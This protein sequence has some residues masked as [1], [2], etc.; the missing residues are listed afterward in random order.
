MPKPADD[1]IDPELALREVLHALTTYTMEQ[2]V[3][4]CSALMSAIV[5]YGRSCRR[6]EAARIFDELGE[7]RR[8]AACTQGR[9]P[10]G[11]AFALDFAWER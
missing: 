11:D 9:D 5:R 2:R 10:A 3:T 7:A 1:R 4:S 6:D 8:A